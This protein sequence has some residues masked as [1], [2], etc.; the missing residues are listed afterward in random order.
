MELFNC[1]I[2]LPFLLLYFQ[3]GEE[4]SFVEM[5]CLILQSSLAFWWSLGKKIF[6]FHP[7]EKELWRYLEIFPS[8]CWHN[9][10][11]APRSKQ[12][13]PEFNLPIHLIQEHLPEV[14]NCEPFSPSPR[15]QQNESNKQDTLL[16]LVKSQLST[17]VSTSF[18]LLQSSAFPPPISPK[19]QI[20][21]CDCVCIY[22]QAERHTETCCWGLNLCFILAFES[23]RYCQTILA[24]DER[25]A[26]RGWLPLCTSWPT[27]NL[28]PLLILSPVAELLRMT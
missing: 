7:C 15:K 23:Q 27:N 24:T 22:A 5:F 14:W 13:K 20:I 18:N 10:R 16:F 28:I 11:F 25:R 8:P 26:W 1:L 9:H 17:P 6:H 2:T 19:M 21:V 3:L 4:K 12:R